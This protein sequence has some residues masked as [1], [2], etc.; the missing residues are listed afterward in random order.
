MILPPR[1][2]EPSDEIASFDCGQPSLDS[3]LLDHALRAERERTA[4]TYVVVEDEGRV[5]AYYSLAAHG[6]ERASIGGG[7]LARN[8]PSLVPAVL[9]ARLAVDKRRQGERLGSSLLAHA[10]TVARTASTL[11]GLRAIVVNP[12]DDTA[13]AFYARY[14]FREFPAGPDRMFYPL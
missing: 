11:I 6:V 10:V 12:V 7:R 5:V 1:R 3:W 9:L 4:T 14:G 13:S 8:A 2:I